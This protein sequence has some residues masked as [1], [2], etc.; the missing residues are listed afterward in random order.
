MNS[1][2]IFV[3]DNLAKTWSEI[4]NVAFPLGTGMKRS[5]SR[6]YEKNVVDIVLRFNN[7]R[8]GTWTGHSTQNNSCFRCSAYIHRYNSYS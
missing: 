3:Y 6:G 8:I 4:P 5:F 1:F 7:Y 2:K